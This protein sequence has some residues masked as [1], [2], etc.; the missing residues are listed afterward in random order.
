MRLSWQ[1]KPSCFKVGVFILNVIKIYEVLTVEFFSK[2]SGVPD[3]GI[4]N[5]QISRCTE[6]AVYCMCGVSF[7]T[8]YKYSKCQM[9]NKEKCGDNSMKI[10]LSFDRM[11][12]C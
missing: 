5:L 4:A 1:L 2:T 10:A 7:C 6:W 8:T 9:F 12:V 3:R 11:S